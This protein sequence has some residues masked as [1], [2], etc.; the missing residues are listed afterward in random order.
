MSDKELLPVRLSHLLRHCSVG[1]VVRGPEY[2]L[3]VMDITNWTDKYGDVAAEEITYVEQVKSALSIPHMLR[4]PPVAQERDNGEIDGV[5]VPAVRFPLWMSCPLCGLLHYKPWCGLANEEHPRCLGTST[6]E[7]VSQP[8][9]EQVP[10]V[11]VHKE[12][13]LTDVP[14]HLLAHRN[15]VIAE[16]KQCKADWQQAYLRIVI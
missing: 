12:G 13:H 2:L 7:C 8:R 14:W 6:K 3:S 1:A 15:A 11:L 4:K 16:Q 10:W 5:C 9:L